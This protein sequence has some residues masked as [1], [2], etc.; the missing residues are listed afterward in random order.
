MP[1]MK[2]VDTTTFD[3]HPVAPHNIPYR[4]EKRERERQIL[5][6]Q[7]SR[8]VPLTGKRV[9]NR[10]PTN[11]GGLCH[12]HALLLF[13]RKSKNLS[14]DVKHLLSERGSVY[15][16]LVQSVYI[17]SQICLLPQAFS[18]MEFEELARDA[19]LLKK[20]KKGKI[21]EAELDQQMM[22]NYFTVPGMRMRC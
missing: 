10:T 22:E 17:H 11:H 18:E 19:R 2:A 12:L 5:L 9:S 13:F 20:F 1:E 16:R 3:S 6:A 15:S 8:K 7:G 21:S 14:R 4:E